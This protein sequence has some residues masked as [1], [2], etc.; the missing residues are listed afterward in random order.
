[1]KSKNWKVMRDVD[2]FKILVQL[3]SSV[4]QQNG[5]KKQNKQNSPILIQQ[6]LL[7]IEI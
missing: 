5:I 1:M 2:V 7:M 4:V 6:M 3:A